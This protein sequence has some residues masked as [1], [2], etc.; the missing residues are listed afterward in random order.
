MRMQPAS[1]GAYLRQVARPLVYEK[2]LSVVTAS[3]TSKGEFRYETGEMNLDISIT[4][5]IR[6]GR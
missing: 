5:S 4:M 3:T 2:E 6:I 1:N